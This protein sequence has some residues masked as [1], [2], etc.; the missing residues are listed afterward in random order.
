MSVFFESTVNQDNCSHNKAA[1]SLQASV[2][3][4]RNTRNFKN[5]PPRLG[6]LKLGEFPK[7]FVS[8]F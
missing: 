6:L 8:F 5:P 2:V 7:N 1:I 3:R 4:F